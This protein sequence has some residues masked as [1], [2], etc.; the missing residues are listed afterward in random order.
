MIKLLP[1]AM[2][3]ALLTLLRLALLMAGGPQA[4]DPGAVLLGGAVRLVPL[5]I[6]L[7]P[8]DFIRIGSQ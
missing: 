4:H 1:A 2:V 5:R 8:A 6:T 3:R 7:R